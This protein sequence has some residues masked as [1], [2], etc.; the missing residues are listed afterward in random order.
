MTTKP[1]PRTTKYHHSVKNNDIEQHPIES[2]PYRFMMGYGTMPVEEQPSDYPSDDYR[3]VTGVDYHKTKLLI[4]K[5]IQTQ[6]I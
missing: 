5:S 4:E 1:I 3:V 6:L 2:M